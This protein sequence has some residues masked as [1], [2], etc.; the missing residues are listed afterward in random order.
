[1]LAKRTAK[2]LVPALRI[3][4][5]EIRIVDLPRTPEPGGASAER[6]EPLSPTWSSCRGFDP[7]I[8]FGTSAC[9]RLT[10]PPPAML[11]TALD[12]KG[13]RVRLSSTT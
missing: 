7:A 12:A 2:V 11:E 8:T 9:I 10:P 5:R 1:M 6:S 3:C 13:P 4:H